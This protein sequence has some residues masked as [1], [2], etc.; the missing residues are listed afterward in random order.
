MWDPGIEHVEVGPVLPKEALFEQRE[1][2]LGPGA[3]RATIESILQQ[4]P[5]GLGIG[6][7]DAG[8]PSPSDPGCFF[9]IWREQGELLIA[10][11]SHGWSTY[12]HRVELDDAVTHAWA[13]MQGPTDRDEPRLR[14]MGPAFEWVG[15]DRGCIWPFARRPR[16][17][18]PK[19]SETFEKR[20]AE[21]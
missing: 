12:A 7:F 5:D 9:A 16:T 2:R 17:P 10:W 18:L 15:P 3:N 4:L 19:P 8:F 11:G 13:C 1:I 21:L 20:L 6:Y 14:L